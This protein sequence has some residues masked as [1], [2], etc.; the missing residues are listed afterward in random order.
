MVT[1]TYLKKAGE[2]VEKVLREWLADRDDEPP[3]VEAF[4]ST[5]GHFRVVVAS[6]FFKD[7]GMMERQDLVA[8]ELRRA[9]DGEKLKLCFGAHVMDIEE[10]YRA[11]SPPN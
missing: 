11:G 8:G 6:D 9:V 5:P 4:E 7:K 1:R 10:Y 3:I 2:E